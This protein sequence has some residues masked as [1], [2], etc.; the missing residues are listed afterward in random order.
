MKAK[1][2]EGPREGRKFRKN[3]RSN[4][5]F[6]CHPKTLSN[7]YHKKSKN[8]L[9]LKLRQTFAE[10][11]LQLAILVEFVILAIFANYFIHF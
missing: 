10:C 1:G 5:N 11:L 2:R 8:T 7:K 4:K 6:S 3:H 9:L